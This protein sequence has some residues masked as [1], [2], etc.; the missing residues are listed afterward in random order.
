MENSYDQG[1]DHT[2]ECLLDYNYFIKHCNMIAIDLSKQQ[3]L[4]VDPN[5]W[6]S[7]RNCFGLFTRK[8]ESIV[9]LFYFDISVYNIK[10]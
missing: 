2:V 9:H 10:L 7:K 1:D 6:R 3:A 4:D 5:Y 8:H